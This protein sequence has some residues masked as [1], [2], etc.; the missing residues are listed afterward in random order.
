MSSAI[1]N[2][3]IGILS[4]LCML[5]ILVSRRI[6][7]VSAETNYRFCCNT[8]KQINNDNRNDN[9][10][11]FPCEK[12]F[13]KIAPLSGICPLF[14]T[15]RKL[16]AIYGG[17]SVLDSTMSAVSV[18]ASSS[19]SDINTEKDKSN[20]EREQLEISGSPSDMSM[21][22]GLYSRRADDVNGRPHYARDQLY[23]K[24]IVHLY[25][26]G[27]QWVLHFD[28]DPSRNFQNL[29][30]Y[31]K[32]KHE[33]VKRANAKWFV[34]HGQSFELSE[35]MLI[36]KPG[37]LP[38]ILDVQSAD[39]SNDDEET[40][41]TFGVPHKLLPFYIVFMLDAIAT[42]IAMPLLPFFIM[43]LGATALQLSL[44]ISSNYVAQMIGCILMG[45]VSD[46]YGRKVVLIICITASSL[47]YFSIS[48]AK[49]LKAVIL[50]KLIAGSFGGLVPVMQSSVADITSTAD[51]P[52]YI[53]RIMAT[54]GLGFVLGP[55]LCALMPSISTRE[56]MRIA[57]LLPLTGIFI[58][59]LFAKE[60]K[61][62][63]TR[64]FSKTRQDEN[65]LGLNVKMKK[66]IPDGI[67]KATPTTSFEVMCLVLNGF[68]LMYAFSTESIYAVFIK[69]SFG[70][71]ERVLSTLFA[72]NGLFIGIFQ[73]FFIKPMINVFG[74]HMTLVFGN[75][76]LALGMLGIALVR[77][78]VPH[79]LLFSLH[80]VGYSIADTAL[81]SL[82]T[83][84]STED[85]QGRD[86]ALNA[87][88]Q[89]SA[90][91][92]SPLIA[93]LLYEQSKKW[94]ALPMGAL[95]F[96][97]GAMAPAIAIAIPSFLY[98]TSVEKKRRLKRL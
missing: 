62:G 26:S 16:I 98:I 66:N 59:I 42:G 3:K 28:L 24:R 81:A 9:N 63:V 1:I 92:L 13:T 76:L 25:W 51:R 50:S 87:A 4:V 97:V 10:T 78:E 53:G 58:A 8:P 5:L 61:K 32:V 77:E 29:L 85:S 67:K 80:V 75:L 38:N 68:L 40:R 72:I 41:V 83:R 17:A 86:L 93:G 84:Y 49:S 21:L 43:E 11:I 6:V 90:R 94:G 82:I 20:S 55:A 95:P 15:K 37:E 47:S 39:S 44:V 70:Y 64:I 46:T 56:K 33:D 34:R 91:V 52:K 27:T 57:T 22:A 7:W 89:A 48:N 36:H 45:R 18:S 71:G 2:C 12:K 54:F 79:F 31:S 65:R 96:L 69:D 30:A 35:K 88:A 19:T 14:S 73:V 74:K 23:K 60:P